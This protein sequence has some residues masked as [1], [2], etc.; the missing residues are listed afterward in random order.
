MADALTLKIASAPGDIN[1]LAALA[2]EIWEEHYTPIIGAAQ[3]KYMVDNFQSTKAIGT[4]IAAGYLYTLAY[5]NGVPC[6][7]SA[8]RFDEDALFLSKLYVLQT[9]R[10]KGIARVMLCAAEDAARQ[11]GRTRI[12]L[13][14]NKNNAGSL[15]AY[16]CM[17]FVRTA[18]I[19]TDI[20]GGFVMDD[21]VMEKP[22]EQMNTK[23]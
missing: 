4:D 18:D 10:G 8:V 21:Y 1:V 14:C 20:G 13:T 17:G 16:A 19:V 12:R 11:H 2:R 6:G 15:A 5:W 23:I 9:F 7:Y 22:L 3:V